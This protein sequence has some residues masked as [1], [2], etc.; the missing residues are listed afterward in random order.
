MSSAEMNHLSD[1]Q[2]HARPTSDKRPAAAMGEVAASSINAASRT[3]IRS[4]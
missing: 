4:R 2:N 3:S 1:F